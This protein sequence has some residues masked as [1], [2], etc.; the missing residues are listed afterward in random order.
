MTP[1]ELLDLVRRKIRLRHYSYRT[2]HDYVYWIKLFVAYSGRRH[3]SEIGDETV[4]RL[5]SHPAKN[6]HVSAATQNQALT[7]LLFPFNY[8]IHRLRRRTERNPGKARPPCTQ[9]TAIHSAFGRS[10]RFQCRALY[11]VSTVSVRSRGSASALPKRLSTVRAVKS[12]L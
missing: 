7:A 10:M 12:A 2:E 1:P 8:V 4:E 11:R 9:V 5:L 3:P 6:R